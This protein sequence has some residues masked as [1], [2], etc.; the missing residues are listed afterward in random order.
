MEAYQERVVK[1]SADLEEK[2]S[3]LHKFIQLDNPTY[4]ALPLDDAKLLI[5]QLGAMME[6]GTVLRA[7]ILR[8]TPAT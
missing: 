7:R 5:A 2:I 8:F 1:E 4:I 3:A 6:Y